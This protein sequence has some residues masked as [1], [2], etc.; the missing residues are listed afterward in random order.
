MP[1]EDKLEF[2]GEV[3]EVLPN[4]LF[5]V[6]TDRGTNVLSTLSGRMRTNNINVLLHD[7]VVVETSVYDLSKG[8]IIFRKK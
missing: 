7:K 8:R 6:K 4:A 1:K 2:E 3:I 5:K